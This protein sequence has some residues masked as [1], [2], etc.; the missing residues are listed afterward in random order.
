MDFAQA[1]YE[2]RLERAHQAMAAA[3]L[4][5]LFFTTEAEMRYFTG[6]RTLF[7]QSPTRPWHLVIPSDGAPIAIIPE[8]G[9]AAMARTWIN[10]IRTWSSPAARD[11]GVSL[12]AGALAGRSR[13]GMPMGRETQLRMPLL[14]FEDLRA[15]LR[16][17]EIVDATALIQALRMVKSP[18]E[19]ACL[20]RIAAIASAAFAEA[21]RLFHAGQALDAAFR[22]FRMELLAQGA[23]D[24]PYLVGGAGPDG[25]DDIISPADA[26]PLRRGDVLMLDTGAALQGYFSDFDRNFA[27]AEAGDAVRR[28]HQ[29]LWQATEA[30]L[31][32]ARPGVTTADLHRAMAAVIGGGE[33]G[34]GRDGG[35]GRMGHGLGMQLTEPPS[36]IQFDETPLRPG[37]VLTLEPS[38][39][40][41]P[42]RVL[43]HEET[44][45]IQDGAPR[46]LSTRAPPELPIIG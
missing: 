19:I 33:D 34:R 14:D 2:A 43:V 44:I 28:A 25:H 30:G 4:D 11:D 1:E 15:R 23:E 26:T 3:G 38:M 27:I 31:A 46:L 7:W 5:A 18:A 17:A 41:V 35:V 45:V 8:I 40:V 21:P 10:D 36:L 32:A 13:I 24:V 37:M 20:A 6:F 16:T 42:G 22:A 29:T 39:T 9:A 12:L